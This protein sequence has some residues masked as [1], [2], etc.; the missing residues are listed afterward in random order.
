MLWGHFWLLLSNARD[1]AY[2]MQLPLGSYFIKML[3]VPT[4]MG[5]SAC[6]CEGISDWGEQQNL[7]YA[8]LALDLSRLA[9]AYPAIQSLC[10]SYPNHG[11]LLRQYDSL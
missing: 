1:F 2:A 10:P 5:K 6:I 4:G 11:A 9:A 3:P 8:K 7:S